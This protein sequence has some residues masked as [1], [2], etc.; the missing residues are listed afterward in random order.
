MIS[1]PAAKGIICSICKP[2]ATDA[3]SGTNSAIASRIV[4]SLD[5][6]F[7]VPPGRTFLE[8]RVDSFLRVFRFHQFFQINLFRAGEA[9]VEVNRIPRID[10]F[11]SESQGR[12]AELRK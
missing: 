2:R 6:L 8:K 10:G 7:S 3:P 4:S 11:L 9:F 12:W 1:C 5:I